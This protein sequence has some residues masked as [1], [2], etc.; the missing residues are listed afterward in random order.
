MSSDRYVLFC[1]SGAAGAILPEWHAVCRSTASHSTLAVGGSSS[2]RLVNVRDK[3]NAGGITGLA[4]PEKVVFD[5]TDNGGA[6][7][8]IA[9]HDGYL[10]RHGVL[11]RRT[12]AMSAD[13]AV[14]DGRDYLG[15]KHKGERLAH[16]LVYDIHFH[17]HPNVEARMGEELDSV[18]LTLP[19]NER[20]RFRSNGAR[21]SLEESTYL[22]EF[23]GPRQS[24]QIVLRG[25][26]LDSVEVDWHVELIEAPD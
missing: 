26:C 2:S 17:I 8:I 18:D 20:W 12:L 1:N 3:S 19:N 11:H 14:V 4:G 10:E 15:P 9:T 16:D 6:T 21:L 25:D 5:I 13:G 22:A 7:R 24:M 23:A